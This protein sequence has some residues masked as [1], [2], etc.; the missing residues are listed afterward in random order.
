MST[1][2]YAIR[3]ISRVKFYLISMLSNRLTVVLYY[4]YYGIGSQEK[5]NEK[6]SASRD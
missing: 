6:H 4:D 3:V 5:K 1:Y 2:I